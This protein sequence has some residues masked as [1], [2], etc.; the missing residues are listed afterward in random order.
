MSSA[1]TIRSGAIGAIVAAIP[2]AAA[3]PV[4]VSVLAAVARGRGRASL[5]LFLRTSW[6]HS[7]LPGRPDGPEWD[8][9]V[10]SEADFPIRF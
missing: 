4:A 5:D 10:R 3:I 8:H 2:G 6:L 9:K 1:P 7:T